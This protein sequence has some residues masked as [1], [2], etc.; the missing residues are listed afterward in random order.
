MVFFTFFY[1]WY[2]ADFF[3]GWCQRKPEGEQDQPKPE[4]PLNDEDHIDGKHIIARHIQGTVKWFNV[5]N[6][7]G[8]INRADTGEDIFVHQTAVTKN[9]PNKYLR[10]LGDGEKVEFDVVEGQKGPEAANV[11]G[12]DGSNVEGSKYAADKS[13]GGRG[14][15][16][17]RRRFY[18]GGYRSGRGGRRATS[19]G[20]N[21]GEGGEEGEGEE[22]GRRRGR[23]GYRGRGRGRG[24]FR[25][26]G[27]GRGGQ[28]RSASEGE[29]Q[30]NSGNGEQSPPQGNAEN[31]TRGRGGRGRGRGG[32]GRRGGRGGEGSPNEGDTVA[33][34]SEK[35]TTPAEQTALPA[36]PPPAENK[37]AT[38]QA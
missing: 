8:F 25:G 3:N 13:E 11:T 26:R 4:V 28:R 7:Y 37:E 33:P 22:G 35:P 27:R 12:P 1:V 38:V 14:G 9:N 21:N 30:E 5:K 24:G 6:G 36:N 19:E 23:G 29:H 34:A 2:Q 20:E 31:G 18:Y 15:R 17:Y 16:G 32:R 10:S